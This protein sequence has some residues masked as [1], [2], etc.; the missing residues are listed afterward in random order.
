MHQSYTTLPTPETTAYLYDPLNHSRHV[1]QH[2]RE[3]VR[4]LRG[5]QLGP[6]MRA[7]SVPCRQVQRVRG[8]ELEL[9]RRWLDVGDD[10]V[11]ECLLGLLEELEHRRQYRVRASRLLLLLLA[12][13]GQSAR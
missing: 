12:V 7:G 2:D 1:R 5:L 6:V 13:L 9:R 11:Q 4:P 10:G 8:R 3:P